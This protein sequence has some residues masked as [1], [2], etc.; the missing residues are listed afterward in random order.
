MR[1]RAFAVRLPPDLEQYV[2]QRAVLEGI[3]ASEV[4]RNALRL[5]IYGQQPSA[6]E[7]YYAARQN[8]MRLARH[9]LT[10]AFHALPDNAEDAE[11][12]LAGLAG[13]PK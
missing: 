3:T 5:M 2:S 12:M 4:I 6:N 13:N 8:A 1:E 7:G 11:T 9:A 10:E